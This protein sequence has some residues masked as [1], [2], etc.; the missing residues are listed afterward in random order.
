MQAGLNK[1]PIENWGLVREKRDEKDGSRRG[2]FRCVAL[3]EKKEAEPNENPQKIRPG[4][5]LTVLCV[6]IEG[7]GAELWANGWSGLLKERLWHTA[8]GG[9][10]SNSSWCTVCE[11]SPTEQRHTVAMH[12]QVRHQ[13]L[14]ASFRPAR[15]D[16][17]SLQV[18]AKRINVADMSHACWF[19]SHAGI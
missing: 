18:E 14:F 8:G 11:D 3:G 15:K 17:R 10:V 1:F 9:R 7:E 13:S 19:T 16:H 2:C 5:W 12:L 4:Y 6:I